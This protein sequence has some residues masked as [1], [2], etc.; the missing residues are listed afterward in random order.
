MSFNSALN[1]SASLIS[2]SHPSE[3]SSALLRFSSLKGSAF[4]LL[5]FK[6][7]ICEANRRKVN[8]D[9]RDV[10][11]YV[12][13]ILD[14]TS[15]CTNVKG[16]D[17]HVRMSRVIVKIVKRNCKTITS[18]RLDQELKRISPLTFHRT[19]ISDG[20]HALQSFQWPK[21]A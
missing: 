9:R 3:L 20:P 18:I 8:C 11:V 15:A 4:A 13:Y 7:V 10:H 16:L 12:F 21:Q 6:T 14:K 19:S 1:P 17:E 2:S 5:M